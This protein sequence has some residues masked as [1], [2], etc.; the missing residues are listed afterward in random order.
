MF[1]TSFTVRYGSIG[2]EMESV[3]SL[4]SGFWLLTSALRRRVALCL[5]GDAAPFREDTVCKPARG[6]NSALFFELCPLGAES[7][8]AWLAS[9]G[10]FLGRLII[11]LICLVEANSG[12]SSGRSFRLE[13]AA[14]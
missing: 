8:G 3:I 10:R 2:V 6:C 11:L 5:C 14:A 7:R 4:G 12:R 13:S 9:A 1:A